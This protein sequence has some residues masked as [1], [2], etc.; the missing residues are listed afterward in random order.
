MKYLLAL[1]LTLPCSLFAQEPTLMKGVP[2]ELKDEKII[3]LEH[4]KI[5]LTEKTEEMSRAEWK[6]LNLRQT[7]HNKVISQAN[8]KL[9]AA[10]LSYPYAYAIASPSTYESLQKAGYRYIL[11]S[12]V[13]SYNHLKEQPKE[14]ELLVFTYYIYDTERNIVYE[15]FELDE[16]KV[17]DF[18][19]VIKK[20]NKAIKKEQK[21]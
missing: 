15:I 9:K 16:M 5:D 6:Y 10:A 7:N 21:G 19:T 18:K 14:G 12:N 11:Q 17:Y 1:L 13:Y 20:L 2:E 8:E 3:F 4:E